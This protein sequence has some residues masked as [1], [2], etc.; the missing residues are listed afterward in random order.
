MGQTALPA[1]QARRRDGRNWCDGRNWRNGSG[2][3]TRTA[4]SSGYTWCSRC[5]WSNGPL[6]HRLDHAC[7][8]PGRFPSSRQFGDFHFTYRY[9]GHEPRLSSPVR[10]DSDRGRYVSSD[11]E[12]LVI[13]TRVA[14]DLRRW[15]CLSRDGGNGGHLRIHVV[16]CHGVPLGGRLSE[17]GQYFGWI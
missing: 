6:E 13:S 10:R 17:P 15:R 16:R 7:H 12:L 4:R 11:V 3:A 1:R 9:G 14:R 8:C 2:R 5:S